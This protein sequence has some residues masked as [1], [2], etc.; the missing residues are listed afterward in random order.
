MKHAS[1]KIPAIVAMAITLLSLALVASA[2]VIGL[3]ETPTPNAHPTSFALWIYSVILALLSLPVYF[4]DAILS[5][6]K[7]CDRIYPVFNAILAAVLLGAIPM[8]FFVGASTGICIWIWNA[9]Y[10][11]IFVLEVIAIK[12]HLDLPVQPPVV[13]RYPY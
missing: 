2:W 7:A 4:A 5:I 11:L 13:P 6:I 10:V 9:Y 8:L 1:F 12:K 3:L